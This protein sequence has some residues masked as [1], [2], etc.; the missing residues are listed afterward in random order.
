TD[1]TGTVITYWA[2]PD[3]FESVEYDVETL[4]KRF[5]QM[6]FLNK[7]LRITLTDERPAPAPE[8]GDAADGTPTE[9]AGIQADV[10][11]EEFAEDTGPSTWSYRYDRGLQ[12]FVEFINN[13]KR[14]E[15]IH[16]E[17]ISFEVE[18][19]TEQ[20]SVEVAMQW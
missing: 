6:A 19:T 14:T 20:I 8:G 5:Q 12:D 7:G 18:D 11:A 3:I 13:A 4:R 15:V 2:D 9:D 1:E 16:P 10:A 17:I